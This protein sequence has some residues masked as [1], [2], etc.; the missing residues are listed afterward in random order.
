MRESHSEASERV[1]TS[2]ELSLE[3]I[4]GNIARFASEAHVVEPR[5]SLHAAKVEDDGRHLDG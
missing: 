2:H 5:V 3:E 1:G 4:R